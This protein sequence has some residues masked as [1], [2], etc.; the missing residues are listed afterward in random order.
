M[1]GFKS[2]YKREIKGYFLTPIAYVFLVIF[3]FFSSF[4][5]FRGGFFQMRQA[6]LRLFFANMPLLFIFMAPAIAMRLWAEERRSN[7]I[8]LLLTLPVTTTQAVLGKFLAAWTVIALAVALTFPMVITVAYLG[9]PDWGPIIAGYAG[10][11]LLA[12]SYLA[13]GSFFSGLTSNQVIAFV[14]AVVA[15]AAF[16]FSGSPSAMEYA[17]RFL[18][19]GLVAAGES[20]SFS[21]RFESLQRGV[22][23]MRDLAFFLILIAG[24]LW[25]NIVVLKARYAGWMKTPRTVLAAVCIGVITLSTVLIAR[26]CVGRSRMDLTQHRNYTLSEGTRKALGK[27]SQPIHLK[28]YYARVAAMK[29]TEGIRYYNNYYL[30]VRSLLE[31]YADIAA[32]RLTLDLLDPRPFS[33]EEEEALRFGL[34]R[35][36][37]SDNESF[38]FGLVAETELGK[39]AVISFFEPD[40]QEFV[41]YDISKLIAEVVQRDK[42]KLGVLSSLPVMGSDMSPY[43]MQMMQMQGRTPEKPWSIVSHLRESYDVAGVPADTDAIP[44][45]IDFLMVVHPKDLAP[46]TLFAI[47]QY[48]MAGGKLMAFVDPHCIQDQ[49]ESDPRNPYAAMSYQARSNLDALLAGW[50]VRMESGVI[51]ADRALAVKAT[52]QRGA[53][54]AALATF[55]ELNDECVNPDEVIA[56]K[57]HSVR[58]LFPGVLRRVPDAETTVTP[59]L[60]TTERGGTWRPAGS[61]ELAM[62]NPDAIMRN[63][64]EAGEPLMLACRITGRLKTNFPEGLPAEA[65]A[66]DADQADDAGEVEGASEAEAGSDTDAE[67]EEEEKAEPLKES[68][69]DAVVLVFSDVDMMTDML[70]YQQSFFGLA[71]VGDNAS[72]VL[73]ALDYLSGSGDLIA[74]RSRGRFSRPFEVVDAIEREAEEATAAQVEAIN[75][76]IASHQDKLRK[77]GTSATEE[78][79]KV[80]QS[81]ALAERKKIQEEIRQAQKELRHLN[82]GKREKIEAL[83]ATLQTRNMVWAPTA[84]LIIAIALALLR[85]IKA[86]RYA[87]RR[88][89]E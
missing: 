15:C 75:A 54:P 58:V 79:M 43:M 85:Y 35:F 55:L 39:D 41:E 49:P 14:L 88:A 68:S 60:T 78:T 36:P 24:W 21:S 6:T 45:D 42:R 48:V 46:K 5:A 56:A 34:K 59:L 32:G 70:A 13:I 8:E 12:G 63:V 19:A 10:T 28:L 3:L 9:N 18:P 1:T 67:T 37:L 29:A 82:A 30:Y 22:I 83:Q 61:Y 47:D 57:L 11:F 74:I 33:D 16:F 64:T 17:S 84:V 71:Q 4:L 77:L 27:L 89:Q 2:I 66:E 73:N 69:P 25:A 62:P 76:K 20:L 23:E 40:R 81:T 44:N 26:K 7:S 87:A 80:I 51:A 31:E 50:G 52:L 38:Y 53:P 86:K 65:G 72:V